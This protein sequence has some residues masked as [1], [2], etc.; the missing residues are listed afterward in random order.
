MPRIL[1]LREC[2]EI[3]SMSIRSEYSIPEKMDL[4]PLPKSGI[5][6]TTKNARVRISINRPTGRP[7]KHCRT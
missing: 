4:P 6:S 5:F 2:D 1:T 3:F 7:F